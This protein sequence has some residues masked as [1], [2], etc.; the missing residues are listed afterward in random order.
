[1]EDDIVPIGND[2]FIWCFSTLDELQT[3]K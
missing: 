1:V 2:R 3:Y